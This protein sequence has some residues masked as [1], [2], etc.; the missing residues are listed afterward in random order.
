MSR[1]GPAPKPVELKILEGN[2]GHRPLPES[3]P[4]PQPLPPTMPRGLM[5]RAQKFWRAHAPKLERLGLLTEV[6][7]AA[8]AMLATHWAIAFEA[9][10]ELRGGLT[11][12]DEAGLVRKHPLLQVLR[13]NSTA[14][15]LWAAEFGLTPSARGKLSIPEPT[16]TDDFFGF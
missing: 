3:R 6:D 9:A 1:K 13:D 7:G 11:T 8:L 5:P 12:V 14:F 15:R 16:D 10:K 2:P 4:R